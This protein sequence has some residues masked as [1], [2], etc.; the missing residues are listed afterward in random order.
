MGVSNQ[1]S[2]K[3]SSSLDSSRKRKSFS[4]RDGPKGVAETLAKWKE[5]NNKIESLDEKAKPTRKVPAKGSKK[6]CMK[7][8]GG[9]ENSRCKFRGVRQRTWGKWVAEIREPNRG[10]RLWLGTFGSAVEAALAYDE[11][12]RV[13]Y[14]PCARLNLPNCRSMNEFSQ[15]GSNGGSSCDSTTTC[16]HSEDS[17]Y[18][19][20]RQM[21]KQDEGE[22]NSRCEDGSATLTMVKQVKE[23]PMEDENEVRVEEPVEM[24]K[25]FNFQNEM[26]DMEELLELMGHRSPNNVEIGMD[27]VGLYEPS[28]GS[29]PWFK[30]EASNQNNHGPSPCET[31]QEAC[32]TAAAGCGFGFSIPEKHEVDHDGF[33]DL[34]DMQWFEEPTRQDGDFGVAADYG[35]DF[36]MPG[37]PEDCNFSMEE[38]GFDLGPDF[39]V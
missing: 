23:E 7:G 6:G 17:K 25:E 20:S 27:R 18:G 33:K 4:R 14:G 24:K 13:M 37:R 35:F 11:A 29:R 32:G 16:S 28:D 19:L 9:P 34:S 8:K 26:F 38:L 31:Q 2:K 15:M 1:P 21:V 39:G 10:S 5:Y 30:N 36:L 12:A 22:S 3:A